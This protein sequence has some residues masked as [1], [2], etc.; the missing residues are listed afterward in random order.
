MPTTLVAGATGYLGRFLVKELHERG[1]GVKA[2]VRDYQRALEAGPHGAPS[3]AGLVDR[4]AI[5]DMKDPSFV[6]DLCIDVDDVITALGVTRGSASPW[7]VD[8][9]ANA[10]LLRS[11]Q[12][13]GVRQ[14]CAVNVLHSQRIPTQLTRAKS[15]LERLVEQSELVTQ[16]VNPTAYFSDMMQILQMAQ[17]GRVFLL[18]PE[19]CINPIS[20]QDLAQFC[21]D[22][23]ER[24]VQ[25]NWDV[26]GPEVFTWQDLARCA[27]DAVDRNSRTTV[28]P[29]SIF[30]WGASFVRRIKPRQA[31]M[32]RFLGWVMSHDCVGALHGTEHLEDAFV[33][34]AG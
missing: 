31:D 21:V 18:R 5:G 7:D 17:R 15:A 19:V 23:Q 25:G 1:V 2:V 32:M 3:L 27:A 10:L 26:G 14:F 24:L 22:K 13:F 33:A 30:D 20:G 28:I 29:M 4:W 9:R 11:A 34:R 16:V 6:A 8:F 12:A